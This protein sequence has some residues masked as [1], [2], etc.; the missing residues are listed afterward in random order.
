M[1]RRIR[2]MLEL[3]HDSLHASQHDSCAKRFTTCFSNAQD[4]L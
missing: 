3:W 2:L 1:W 4:I